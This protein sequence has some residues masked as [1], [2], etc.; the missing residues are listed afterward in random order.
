MEVNIN[1][2]LALTAKKLGTSSVPLVTQNNSRHI[3]NIQMRLWYEKP[4]L[5][6]LNYPVQAA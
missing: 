1:G 3:R 6:Y 4:L 5:S 2:G